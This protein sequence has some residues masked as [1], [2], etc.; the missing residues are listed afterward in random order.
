MILQDATLW[1]V[2]ASSGIGA[3]LAPALAA[4]GAR[5]AI[6]SRREEEL[7]AVA[8]ITALQGRRPLVKPIDVTDLD[9]VRRVHAELVA[10]WGKVDI[11]FYNAGTR[12]QA[13]VTN[14]HTESAVHQ[15]DVN[16]LG[17][18]RTTGVVMPDML[19]R[20]GGEI[21][22]VGSL[23]GYAGFPRSAA[24]SSSKV[25]VNAYLQSLRIDLRR[26]GVGVTTIN[27]GWVD[28]P[29]IADS[30]V[31]ALFMV[32]PGSA[33]ARIVDG[34]LDGREEIHFPRRLSWPLKVFTAL[35]RPVYEALARRL[36]AR[37]NE[38]S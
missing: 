30:G 15:V 3:A 8:E 1:L 25:A 5:L 29:L 37:R 38:N 33:A 6:S 16:Y 17:L 22:G 11:L 12:A 23:A 10:E 14:F 21:I 24:Y 32:S 27:P 13:E 31:P 34:L 18:I 20:R 7:A 26:F 9:A 2:G 28:T 19:A 4:Q 35:P 36:M